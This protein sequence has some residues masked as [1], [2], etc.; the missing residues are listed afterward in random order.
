MIWSPATSP[1]NDSATGSPVVEFRIS[2]VFVVELKD[3]SDVVP[4]VRLN[5]E[6]GLNVLVVKLSARVSIRQVLSVRVLEK[7]K[8][9]LRAVPPESNVSKVNV[10]AVSPKLAEDGRFNSKTD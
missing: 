4:V 10:S 9:M 3:I 2:I 8:E 7:S 5:A 1:E 6:P